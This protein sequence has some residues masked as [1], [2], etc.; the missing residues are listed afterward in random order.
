M[1]VDDSNIC[2]H[3]EER[4]RTVV[5]RLIEAPLPLDFDFENDL[6]SRCFIDKLLLF[7][8]NSF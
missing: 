8:I 2:K 5:D 1:L 4:W 6:Y 3:L 7:K